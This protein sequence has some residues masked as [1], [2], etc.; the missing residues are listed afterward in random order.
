MTYN[1]KTGQLEG[2]VEIPEKAAE[3]II[4]NIIWGDSPLNPEHD[5]RKN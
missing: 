2:E 5:T 1:E 3:K 4:N